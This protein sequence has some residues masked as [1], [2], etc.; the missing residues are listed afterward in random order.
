MEHVLWLNCYMILIDIND[1]DIWPDTKQFSW[2]NV[3]HNIHYKHFIEEFLI[4]SQLI[5]SILH[6]SFLRSYVE[7]WKSRHGRLKKQAEC[8]SRCKFH[9]LFIF[10]KTFFGLDDFLLWNKHKFRPWIQYSNII[11]NYEDVIYH[12]IIM[13][14]YDGKSMSSF[15]SS[16]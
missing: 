5:S 3:Y 10:G 6:Q 16:C 8:I 11:R 14:I 1:P 15:L 12:L 4:F 9:S 7:G 13:M 2:K